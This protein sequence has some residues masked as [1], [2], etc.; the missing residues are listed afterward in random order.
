MWPWSLG[1][2]ERALQNSFAECFNNTMR[3]ALLNRE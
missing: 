3:D 2:S 1:S